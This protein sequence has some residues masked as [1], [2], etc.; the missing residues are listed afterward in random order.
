MLNDR[1]T[2]PHR[3]KLVIMDITDQGKHRPTKVARILNLRGTVC[4]LY[5]VHV[6]WATDERITFTGDERIPNAEGKIV[7]YKQ[8]RLCNRDSEST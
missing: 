2:V 8:S 6:V 3:G 4:E 1:S 5:D 7:S